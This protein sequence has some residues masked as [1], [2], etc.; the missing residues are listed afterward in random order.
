MMNGT[1]SVGWSATRPPRRSID[2]GAKV[3]AGNGAGTADN[4]PGVAAGVAPEGD[5]SPSVYGGA[6]GGRAGEVTGRPGSGARRGSAHPARG[7]EA[8]RPRGSRAGRF[9][10]ARD[11]LQDP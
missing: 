3:Q 1:A 2:D 9:V 11:D 10:L 4:V 6:F 8:R 5:G 7:P